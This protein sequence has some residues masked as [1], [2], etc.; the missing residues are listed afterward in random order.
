MRIFARKMGDIA[1]VAMDWDNL[2]F[3]LALAETG[4]LSRAAK[5]H[6]VDHSTVARRVE[7]LERELARKARHNVIDGAGSGHGEKRR[8][9][10]EDLRARIQHIDVSGSIHDRVD[11]E[12][13]QGRR[14]VS[15]GKLIGRGLP[16]RADP[17]DLQIARVDRV[18]VALAVE[19]RADG[20]LERC[21]DELPGQELA[22]RHRAAPGRWC[23]STRRPIACRG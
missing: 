1:Q 16:I 10:L 23:R 11:R 8:R 15:R 3:F 4:S 2:K 20:P 19:S 13:R 5:L 22:S 6:R 7:A 21:A 12:D 18:E 14:G 17:D 9:D